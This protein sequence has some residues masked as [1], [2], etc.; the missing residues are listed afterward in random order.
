MKANAAGRVAEPIKPL[1]ILPA[2]SKGNKSNIS[3]KPC[4]AS[5]SGV[6]SAIKEMAYPVSP[7]IAMFLL[8]KM[9]DALPQ[10]ALVKAHA[11]AEI[12]KIVDVCTS[13]KPRSLA[14]GGTRTKAKDWP[15]PTENKPI[16]NQIFEPEK[17]LGNGSD[18]NFI[19]NF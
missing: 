6:I 16:F 7:I 5:S 19:F 1:I 8:P 4:F 14:N 2:I 12:A 15:R 18:S 17:I 9:S 10:E 3:I 11:T 13:D